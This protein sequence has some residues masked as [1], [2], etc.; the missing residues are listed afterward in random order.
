MDMCN[1]ISIDTSK[2]ITSLRFLLI[3]LVV[4]IHNNFTTEKIL[5]AEQFGNTILF[6]QNVFGKWVQ[7]FISNAIALC[8]VPVFFM[9]SSFLQV[10]KGLPYKILIKK[11]IQSLLIPFLIW[12]LLNLLLT[13]FVKIILPASIFNNSNAFSFITWKPLDW[14][15]FFLGYDLSSFDLHPYVGQFWFIRDLFILIII[16][17]LI[18]S[19]MEKYPI[20][21]FIFTLCVYFCNINFFIIE[22]KSFFYYI[23]GCYWAI[24]DFDLFYFVDKIKMICLF[25]IFLMLFFLTYL[26][27]KNSYVLLELVSCL[28]I[29]KL[30]KVII[31]HEKLNSLTRRLASYSFFLFCIHMPFLLGALQK[32][33]IKLFPMKNGFFCLFEYF[34]VTFLTIIIGTGIG[35]ILKKCL[36]KT[37]SFVTGGRK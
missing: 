34:C 36:P 27:S 13:S 30:S 8:A 6:N 7:L 23:M 9:F 37:F 20:S 17:P 29:L 21:F 31:S 18:L 33:W 26:I 12:P 3:V 15:H 28:M 22:P 14:F 32:L 1:E 35:L 11:R 2:R 5:K 4:F 16:S 25:P 19:I 24:Y 10:K